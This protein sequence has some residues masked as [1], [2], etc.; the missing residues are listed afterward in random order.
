VSYSHYDRLSAMDASFLELEDANAHMHMATV[1]L[2]D[3]EPLKTEKGGLDFDRILHAASW[4]MGGSDR[5]RQKLAWI[6]GVRHPVWID[7]DKFNLLY[8]VRHTAL[9]APGGVRQLKRLAGR[10]LSQQLDRGKPL[11]ETWY[12]EG[13]EGNRFAVITKIH[14][15]LADGIAGAELFAGMMGPQPDYQPGEPERWIPRP[16]PSGARLWADEIR[17]RVR[18]PLTLA[19]AATRAVVSGDVLAS[20]RRAGQ[21]LGGTVSTGLQSASATPFNSDLGPHRRFD[22]TRIEL[23]DALEVKQRFGGKLNDVA[24]A[25]VAGAMR[26]FLQRRG[27]Q[28]ENIDFRTIVPVNVRRES[29]RGAMGNRVSQMFARLPIDEPDPVARLGRVIELTQGLKRSHQEAGVEMLSTLAEW[30]GSGLIAGAA[31]LGFWLRS[32][33]LIVTNVPGPRMPIYLLGARMQEVYPTVPLGHHQALG[34]AL[35]SYADGLHWGFNADWDA[36]PDLHHLVDAI[37]RECQT[38]RKAADGRPPEIPAT[39]GEG[40]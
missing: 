14:H 17:R 18:M 29:Q 31:R 35:F 39:P 30:F 11:W 9:P 32:A 2:F 19:V 20:A 21:G 3:A 8:H 5:L 23:A 16:A 25:V 10:I 1:A 4:A 15:S 37:D 22:W 34:I 13:I 28:I 33:N 27:A 38:L 40:A 6:P 7:D 24:L 26:N 12:V 36:L